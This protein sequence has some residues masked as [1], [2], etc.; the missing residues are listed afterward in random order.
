M[1]FVPSGDRVAISPIR[2]AEKTA[3]GV[4][5]PEQS[6]YMTDE[7]IVLAV[8][9]GRTTTAGIFVPTTLKVGQRVAYT[10]YAGSAIKIDGED[11]IVLSERDILGVYEHAA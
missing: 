5:L 1:N 3:A 2:S 9:R 4:F 6:Q 10:R 7:G 8:G 11:A